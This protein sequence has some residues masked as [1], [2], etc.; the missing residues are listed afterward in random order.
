MDLDFTLEEKA[1]REEVRTWLEANKPSEP[2]PE[3]DDLVQREYDLGWQRTLFDNGWAGIAWPKAYGGRELG[4]IAQLIWF[5]EY[6]KAKAPW[7]GANFVGINHGGP[8][9]IA[10]ASEEQKSFHLPKILKGEVVWCQGFSEP[11]AG[12]DLASLATK[13]VVD[14][15]QL[16]ITG[17][18]IWTSF[19]HLADYQ[20]LL[21]RTDTN[22]PKHKGITWVICDMHLPGITIRQIPTMNRGAEFCE[23]FYDEVRVPLANVVGDLNDGW[24]VAMSTLS[25][26]RGTG[27]MASIIELT[28]TIDDL[29]DLAKHKTSPDGKRTYWQDDEYRRKLAALKAEIVALRSSTYRAISR[30]MRQ[31]TPG[32]EGSIL[33]MVMSDVTQKLARLGVEILGISALEFE[34]ERRGGGASTVNWLGS[35]SA[36]SGGGT[37]EIQRNIIS[38]RVLGMPRG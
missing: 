28:T 1:F 17:Q 6:A 8:T 38:E 23:V 19:A 24:S 15:D 33:K 5:E 18:K 16:V 31:A 21:V 25:F 37:T 7:I 4:T 26:E 10:R 11:G 27:F 14:G 12:S 20:E 35:F 3:S 13:A 36:S 29:I 32:P 22:A 30:N 34:G 2:R 9:L